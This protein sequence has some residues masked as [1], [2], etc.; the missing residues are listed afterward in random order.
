MKTHTLFVRII[1]CATLCV[2]IVLI[3]QGAYADDKN[4]YRMMYA[5]SACLLAAGLI[6]IFLVSKGDIH[7]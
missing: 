7:D 5:T 4:T 1:I 6:G 3:A 2:L